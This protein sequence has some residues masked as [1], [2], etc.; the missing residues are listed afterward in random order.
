M[1]SLGIDPPNAWA[2]VD[3]D[4]RLASGHWRKG[5]DDGDLWYRA[6]QVAQEAVSHG[7]RLAAVEGQWVEWRD[8]VDGRTRRGQTR[9]ALVTARHAGI[10]TGACFAAGIR[11]VVVVAPEEWRAAVLPR[12]TGPHRASRKAGAVLMAKLLYGVDVT[13]DEAEALGVARWASGGE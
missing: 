12:G 11:T 3:G 1:I 8:C 4:R 5:L 6:F 13:E 7:V 10:W 2:A 9:G